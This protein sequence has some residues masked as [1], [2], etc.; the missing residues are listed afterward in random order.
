MSWACLSRRLH[1]CLPE[2]GN[3]AG[4]ENTDLI[5]CILTLDDVG[6]PGTRL[7]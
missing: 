2:D 7:C 4:S 6:S 3:G 1:A 5:S